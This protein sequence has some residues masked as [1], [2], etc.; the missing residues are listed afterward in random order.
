M[1]YLALKDAVAGAGAVKHTASMGPPPNP[2]NSYK[3]HL[4]KWV[5]KARLDI[6]LDGVDVD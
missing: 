5:K 6:D 4:E 2:F 1:I 3:E